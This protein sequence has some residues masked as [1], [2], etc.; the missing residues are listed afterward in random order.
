MKVTRRRLVP[1]LFALLGIPTMGFASDEFTQIVD[2]AH[3][4][5]NSGKV[6]QI[7][8]DTLSALLND[9]DPA[10]DP[11]LVNVYAPPEFAAGH[12]KGAINVP[13]GV[14]WKASNLAKLPTD[15]RMIVIHCATGTG[16]IGPATVLS[17][18]GYNARQLEWGMMGWTRNDAALGGVDRFPATQQDYPTV[19]VTTNVAVTWPRPVVTTAKSGL[20]D[21]L[22]ARADA[23]E[24][25]DRV[26][27]MSAEQVQKALT[28][29]N[30]SASLFIVDIRDGA[31]YAKGHIKGAINIPAAKVYEPGN[32]A[33][34][35]LGRRIVIVDYNGRTVVGTSYVLSMLG[36]DARGLMYGMMGWSKDDKHLGTARRFP[37]D[38]K[39]RPIEITR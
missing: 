14:L 1:L 24:A 8:S 7:D 28:A 29:A 9:A 12:I 17:M 33:K 26:V 34:L 27:S 38:H 20:V 35:P 11:L 30:A 39:D 3:A 15:G 32:L 10:N 4:L 18:M 5:A 23:V 2:A 19:T 37:I 13:R 21:V 36:Y 22:A 6:L 16:G 25:A 31:D